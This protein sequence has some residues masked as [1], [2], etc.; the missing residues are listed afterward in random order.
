MYCNFRVCASGISRYYLS[1]PNLYS[2]TDPSQW[3]VYPFTTEHFPLAVQI[4]A[5]TTE[6]VSRK[7]LLLFL[8]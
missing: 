8:R 4:G 1:K 5:W 3:S 6:M 2:E 7:F